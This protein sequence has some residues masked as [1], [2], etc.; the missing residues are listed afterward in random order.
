MDQIL[1]FVPNNGGVKG[2]GKVEMDQILQFV[3]NN[4]GVRGL[5][6][7]DEKYMSKTISSLHTAHHPSNPP[8]TCRTQLETWRNS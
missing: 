3:L 4:G 2:V 1:Q 8:S 6:F 5:G 7:V